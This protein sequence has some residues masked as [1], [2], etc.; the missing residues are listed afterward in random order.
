MARVT[1]EDC[2]ERINNQFEL[3][4]VASKRARKLENG[5]HP[6]LPVERDKPTVL[7]LRE[8]AEGVV[9]R[10]SLE[11]Q[12]A[13]EASEAM[14]AEAAEAAEEAAEKAQDQH[15]DQGDSGAPH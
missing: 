2:I 9:T 6:E 10:E 15:S 13:R 5:A 12:E 11:E 4:L 8:I 3:V 14:A 7:A 1:I